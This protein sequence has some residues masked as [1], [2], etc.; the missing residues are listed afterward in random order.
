MDDQHSTTLHTRTFTTLELHVLARCLTMAA[1]MVDA[2]D[3]HQEA[4]EI[5][6]LWE[7]VHPDWGL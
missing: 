1:A 7:R 6:Q 3:E 5:M 2:L 4:R